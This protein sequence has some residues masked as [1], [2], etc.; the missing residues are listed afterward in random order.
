ML[1]HSIRLSFIRLFMLALVSLLVANGITALAASPQN[2]LKSPSDVVRE[3]Y[4][5]MREQ[6]FREAFA[7]T[8]YKP[9]V[10]SLTAEDLEDLG[11][12]FE[13]KAKMIP[14]TVEITGEQINGN[15]AIVFVRVPIAETSAQVTSQPVN[16]AK[17]GGAWMIVLGSE[18][19]QE[20]VR[21]AGRRY[22]L[23]AMI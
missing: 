6:R 3:F 15:T 8:N 4:K 20:V 19:D 11:P 12:T 21:K 17:S 1:V 2:T 5:A 16:L 22:F 14:E 18:S 7:L 13:D 23:D 9:A 10:E